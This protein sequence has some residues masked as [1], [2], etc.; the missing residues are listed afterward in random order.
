M[1]GGLVMFEN[2]I[3]EMPDELEGLFKCIN[4]EVST[5][6]DAIYFVKQLKSFPW[7]NF[8]KA[9]YFIG[10]SEKSQQKILGAKE[11]YAN[12]VEDEIA[13]LCFDNTAFGSSD[14]GCLVTNKGIYI[15]NLMEK[16]I[17]IK[18][19]N[20]NN[21]ELRGTFD[22]DL[23]INDYKLDLNLMESDDKEK[24]LETLIIIIFKFRE[25]KLNLKRN[26]KEEDDSI[27]YTFEELQEYLCDL[28]ESNGR[29]NFERSVY[30]LGDGDKA[31]NKIKSAIKAYANIDD[32]EIPLVCFDNTALGAADDG[33]VITTKG[34]YVH[35]F[36][37]KVNFFSFKTFVE[38]ESRGIISKDIYINEYKMAS[39]CM[40]S[41]DKD[42]FAELINVLFEKFSG[43]GSWHDRFI[44]DEDGE[45]DKEGDTTD[46]NEKNDNN[47]SGTNETEKDN[48]FMTLHECYELLGCTETDSWDEV[49]R[50][51]KALIK[52][53]HPDL[54]A[55]APQ[56][57]VDL[58]NKKMQAFNQAYE[59][60]KK[61]KK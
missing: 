22:K 40:A 16:T 41:G 23:F 53:Y 17:F 48:D 21:I 44:H 47:H 50:S 2:G 10:E 32:N 29:F 55:N 15:H 19:K 3:N 28:R 20:I 12:L 45:N 46:N 27:T 8:K 6:D 33:C 5:I 38:A 13:F 35:N 4:Y 57:F 61:Y 39:N 60:I 31:N 7:V 24:F 51:Y 26:Y 14:D 37:E 9:I 52:K 25:P 59:Q 42:G 34:V 18:F 36:M 1:N 54:Y 11:S 49:R 30:Y 43:P 58:A 56:E